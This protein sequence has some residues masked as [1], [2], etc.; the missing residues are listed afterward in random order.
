MS[1]SKHADGG[2]EKKDLIQG[3]MVRTCSE[4]W[5]G[6]DR[7]QTAG[8]LLSRSPAPI[9]V[10]SHT[11][12]W[13]VHMS[14]DRC[15]SLRQHADTSQTKTDE[16]IRSQSELTESYT[17]NR[18]QSGEQHSNPIL[19]T[20]EL[21]QMYNCSFV[22]L[23]CLAEIKQIISFNVNAADSHTILLWSSLVI[24]CSR[25]FYHCSLKHIGQT[26]N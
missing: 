10:P 20:G 15:E 18:A 17:M 22:V 14:E 9:S 13:S 5:R 12:Y 21:L 2:G 11:S 16:E 7:L 1:L 23:K 25:F 26:R 4:L 6:R 19:I 8:D 24:Y 3:S